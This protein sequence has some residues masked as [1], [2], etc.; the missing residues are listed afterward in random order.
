MNIIIRQELKED[1]ARIKEINDQAFKQEDESRLVN[2]LRKKNQFIPELSL[3]A[4]TGGTV[5]GHILFYPV[6]I[7]SANQKHITLS[8]GPMSVL[9][10]Y[11]K[12][13]IGGKLFNE[14]LKRAKDLG[15][16][17]VIV[18]GHPKYYP[19][20]GFTKASKWSI[21]VPF[22]VPD[23][24]FMALEIVKNELHDK[25]GIIEYPAEFVES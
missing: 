22:K 23:E 18:V 24:V 25:P 15:F 6:K 17:S 19:K 3:V 5:V 9:P 4:E 16:R 11:Q 8:L 13:G 7:N 2:K 20:F 12:K 10:D 14:G 1:H 21:K